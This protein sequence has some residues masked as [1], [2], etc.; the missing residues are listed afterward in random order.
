MSA[1]VLE[2]HGSLEGCYHRD[3]SFM[4][5]VRLAG[6]VFDVYEYIEVDGFCPH[7]GLLVQHFADNRLR[8]DTGSASVSD[9]ITL[10]NTSV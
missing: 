8:F 3:G 9:T 1:A 5:V 2:V 7:L 6:Y 10:V 4:R